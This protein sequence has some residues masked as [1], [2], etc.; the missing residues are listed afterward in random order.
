MTKRRNYLINLEGR[1]ERRITIHIYTYKDGTASIAVNIPAEMQRGEFNIEKS[2]SDGS[3]RPREVD[4]GYE[5]E[6]VAEKW[7]HIEEEGLLYDNLD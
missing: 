3:Y 7:S 1:M 2:N 5:T 4:P 6:T